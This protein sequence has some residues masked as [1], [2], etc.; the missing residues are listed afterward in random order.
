[1]AITETWL[2]GYITDAQVKI[3]NYSV[4]RSDRSARIHGGSLI[5]VHDSLLV[6]D[7]QSYDDQ[8][9]NCSI[10]TIDDLDCVV[11][12]VYRPPDCTSSSFKKMLGM[13][14][15]YIDQ[16]GEKIKDIYITGDFNLPNICWSDVTVNSSLGSR[17]TD[18]ANTLL[19]FMSRNFMSQMVNGPTRGQNTLDLVLTNREQYICEVSSSE[20]N[21]SDHNLVTAILGFDARRNPAYYHRRKEAEDFT[22]FGLYMQKADLEA[23][24]NKLLGVDWNELRDLCS[25]DDDD[26]DGSSFAELVRLTTLQVCYEHTPRKIQPQADKK[27]TISKDRRI[28]YRKKRKLKARLACLISQNP[29]ST[30]I[31]SIREEI[32]LTA[33][34]IQQQ[35]QSEL[36]QREQKAVSCVKSNPRYFFS[37]AKRF[38]KLKSNIGPLRAKDTGALTRD[39]KQMA[40]CLQDQYASVF[41]DPNA[42]TKKDT[43]LN[44]TATDSTTST[45]QFSLE[46]IIEAI[47]EMDENSATSDGD[48]PARIIKACKGSL[49]QALLLIWRPSLKTGTIPQVYKE[50]FITPVYKKGNKTDPAN[51]RPVSLTSHM[52]KIFERVMRKHLVTYLENNKLFST[53]QHGFRKGRSCLTQL[54]QHMDFITNNYLNDAETDVIYLDY[55]KAFDKVDHSLLLKKVHFYGIRGEIYNWI[56][57]FLTNRTQKVVV[58]GK[59]S[60]PETVLSGVPQGTVLGPILFLIF[61]NDMEFCFSETDAK[62]GSFADDTRVCRKIT[63]LHDCKRLQDDLN[64]IIQWSLDNNMELHEDKF[65]LISYRKPSNILVQD[66]LPFMQDICSYSTPKGITIEK[67]ELVKDLGVYMSDDFSWTTHISRMVSSAQQVASW[68]LGVFR[69]R[70]RQT[71]LQLYKSLIRSRVEYSSPLWN[72]HKISDIQSIENIQRQFTRRISG[73]TELHYWDRLKSLKLM[74]LQRRRERYCIIHVWKIFNNICPNDIEMKFKHNPRLGNKVII[75]AL[76]TKASKAAVSVYDHSFKV[77]AAQ[78]WNILPK[79]VN[80]KITLESFKTALGDMLQKLPDEPPVSGYTTINNNTIVDWCNQRG[81]LQKA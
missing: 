57:Q 74:S 81:G 13:I 58:D 32:N 72:P 23:I 49:A 59:H 46:D 28:L 38:S 54:L 67:S 53:K 44:L 9:C 50:Q 68:V 39:P 79:E 20:T 11:A 66:A 45:F 77:S 60:R 7:H 24:N 43:T 34:G 25:P 78:M 19:E 12:S 22:Y 18:S 10:V 1:M 48:I 63:N 26:D 37:Y 55:A 17:G 70:S 62:A 61:A 14:Q 27:L 64:C 35:I 3:K 33:Y 21:L 40:E 36:Y 15:N 73:L 71:M 51:Y 56:K 41:S 75:P 76:N 16:A 47:N 42:E 69:D 80:E 5:Y 65:E 52:I 6:S 29:D 4:F 8:Y 30:C 31:P 2:K